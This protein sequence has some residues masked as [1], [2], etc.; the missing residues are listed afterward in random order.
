MKVTWTLIFFIFLINVKLSSCRKFIR[1][2][3]LK[4]ETSGKTAIVNVC[5]FRTFKRR[6]FYTLA[7][8]YSRTVDDNRISIDYKRKIQSEK[9]ETF[10]KMENIEF[11]K[12]LQN[13]SVVQ[14]IPIVGSSIN[15]LWQFGNVADN[16]IAKSNYIV[17]SNVTWDTFEPV[18]LL[19]KGE[20]EFN[21]QWFDFLDENI[22]FF[23][24]FA[25]II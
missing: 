11:C 12:V 18:Q 5:R 6:S 2:R 15:H 8:N 13:N 3:R 19:P 4:C 21:Y 17:M 23:Q 9:L 20:Y 22:F 24:M 7:L 10:L 14:Y 1:I 25:N 16:C